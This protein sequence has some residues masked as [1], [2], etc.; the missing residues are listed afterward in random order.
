MPIENF[1]KLDDGRPTAAHTWDEQ[2]HTVR[3]GKIIGPPQAEHLQ[4]RIAQ[5]EEAVA[6]PEWA[7]HKALKGWKREIEWRRK[8]LETLKVTEDTDVSDTEPAE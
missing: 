3:E 1:N 8:Q 4:S 7:A 5:L 6:N 2:F